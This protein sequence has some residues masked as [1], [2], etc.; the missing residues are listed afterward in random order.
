MQPNQ[1]GAGYRS[2]MPSRSVSKSH[3]QFAEMAVQAVLAV[4]DLERKDVDFEL[5]KVRRRAKLSYA[6]PTARSDHPPPLQ[7]R[8][9]CGL[10]MDGKVGGSLEDSR[11]V[12]GVVIDKDISHPQMD[13]E[14]RDARIWC[15][16]GRLK[17][18]GCGGS[19]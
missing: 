3:R 6:A 16:A 12:Y 2:A 1:A 13:K 5:I 8:R 7:S 19:R 18:H 15:V 17:G 9:R 10:Q 11:L 4:A 14:I